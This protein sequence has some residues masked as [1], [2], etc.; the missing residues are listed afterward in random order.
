MVL[1]IDDS[2]FFFQLEDN[3]REPQAH[4]SGDGGGPT[5]GIPST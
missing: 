2:I 3:M 1:S 4:L 5:A